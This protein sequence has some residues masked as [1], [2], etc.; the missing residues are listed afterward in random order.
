MIKRFN[1][2]EL[3]YLMPVV[4]AERIM[5]DLESMTT[6]DQHGGRKGYPVTSLYYDSPDL[7]CFWAKIEGIKFRRKLRIRIYPGSDIEAVNE[8]MLEIKQRMNR[9]VQKRR[10]KLPLEEGEL[11]CRGRLDRND[12]DPMDKQVASEIQ[13]MVAAMH[14]VPAAIT[15]Y[16]RKAF[17]GGLYDAGLRITFDTDLRGRVHALKVNQ[18]AI[19][20][21]FAPP[22]SCS[23]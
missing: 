7:D 6:P 18:K 5:D 10:L 8:G 21:L 20:H 11:L 16:W 14:L 17:V 12:L 23:Q 2:Y 19:N 13:Y 22:D 15:A 3:K 1:R 4:Q 9:T